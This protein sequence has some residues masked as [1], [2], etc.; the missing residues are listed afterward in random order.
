MN[1]Y[2]KLFVC[3]M[4]WFHTML[5]SGFYGGIVVHAKNDDMPALFSCC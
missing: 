5:S 1:K 4:T 3:G 2:L